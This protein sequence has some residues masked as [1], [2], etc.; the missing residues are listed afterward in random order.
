L[1]IGMFSCAM[2]HTRVMPN[3][4]VLKGA[5][6]NF[7]FERVMALIEHSYADQPAVMT[8]L[9]RGS[10]FLYAVPWMRPDPID[11]LT[12][13]EV[14][15]TRSAIPAGVIARQRSTPWAPTQVPDLIGVRERKY[16]DRTG[17]AQQRD[18]GDLMRYAA[19]N[20]GADALSSFGGFVPA[21]AL[22]RRVAPPS[23]FDRYSDEQ[24]YALGLYLY[25]L[26]PPVNP[27]PFGEPARRGREI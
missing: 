5:Q 11:Q 3:G 15:R 23:T 27:N 9:R 22:R 16:L 12:M 7:P 2:C 4:S 10:R 21:I 8:F 25:S 24:L 18:I 26:A 19:L 6:G 13:E 20:Q 1:E 14:F 17:V